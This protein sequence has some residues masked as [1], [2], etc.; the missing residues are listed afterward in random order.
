MPMGPGRSRSRLGFLE[1][2]TGR[3]VVILG[4]RSKERTGHQLRPVR[5]LGRH[6]IVR[7]Q[8]DLTDLEAGRLETEIEVE[9][10]EIPELLGEQV[11]IPSRGLGQPVVGDHIRPSL[12]LGQMRRTD[13]WYLVPV[14]QLSRQHSAMAGDHFESGVH[15]HRA[16]ES[17]G[18]DAAGDLSGLP[19]AMSAGVLRVESQLVDAVVDDRHSASSLVTYLPT[20]YG[21]GSTAVVCVMVEGITYD[22]FGW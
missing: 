20:V 16:I 8:V 12:R 22:A 9:L 5:P 2:T 11:L 3:L 14:E 1:A 4:D 7:S 13:R 18:L 6:S 19:R 21:A 17:E 15:Q 10:R